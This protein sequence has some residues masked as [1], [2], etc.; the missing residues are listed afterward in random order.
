MDREQL[1]AFLADGLS[2]EEIGRRVDRHP[3]T[4]SYWLRKHGL[5]AANADRHSARGPIRRDELA[6][7]VAAGLSTRSIA[8][9]LG[10]SQAA[11]R[12]WLKVHGLQTQRAA[13][14]RALAAARTTG[15]GAV[16]VACPRHGLTRH[17]VVDGARLRCAKCRADA[18]ADRRRRV[19]A[20][21]VAEAGGRCALCGY[22]RFSGALQFHHLDPTEKAFHL[23]QA[24]VTRSLARARAEAAKCMLLCAN[25]HAE[26]EGGAAKLPAVAADHPW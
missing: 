8:R 20:I 24:G 10:I 14:N 25:C 17:V 4:V 12:R 26:V 21:L 15:V 19:K 7:L 3:S 2:L 5:R 9:E 18:V 6:R 16:D 22:D 11:A 1:E 13:R 23:S